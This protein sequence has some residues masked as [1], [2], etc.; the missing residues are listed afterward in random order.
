M[1]QQQDNKQGLNV[2]ARSPFHLYYSGPAESVSA[3]NRVGDFD[4]LPG[5]ADF[6]SV[7]SPGSVTI[8][9]SKEPVSFDITDGILT[10]RNDEVMIFVNI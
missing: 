3:V 5:H 9:T 6:F 4:V 1:S 10:V 2:V 7:L 8:E